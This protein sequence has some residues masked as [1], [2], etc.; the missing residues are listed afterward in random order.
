MSVHYLDTLAAVD[1]PGSLS[2]VNRPPAS[3]M[4]LACTLEL[5][6]DKGGR[7]PGRYWVH[8]HGRAVCI[9]TL[10]NRV[11]WMPCH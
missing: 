2:F 1:E 8:K 5:E 7:M 4:I 11:V 9:T 10:D 6:D 3:D